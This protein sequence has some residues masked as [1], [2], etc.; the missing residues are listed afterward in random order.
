[1]RVNAFC[2]MR[3]GKCIRTFDTRNKQFHIKTGRDAKFA[4]QF[5]VNGV[6]HNY[7]EDR[8]AAVH[9]GVQLFCHI[10]RIFMPTDNMMNDAGVFL[11]DQI[12]A[13]GCNNGKTARAKDGD[14]VHNDLTA[15]GEMAGQRGGT[16]RTIF[17]EKKGIEGLSAFCCIHDRNSFPQN[18]FGNTI[19]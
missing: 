16:D 18:T 8:T 17:R 14:I 7:I 10:G 1:M 3:E 6:I 2:E 15:D 9:D 12:T 5:S 4:D 13:R 19:A 11:L